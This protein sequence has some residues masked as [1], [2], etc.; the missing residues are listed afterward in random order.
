[1]D[2]DWVKGKERER[3][4]RKMREKE[5]REKTAIVDWLSFGG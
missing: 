5:G 4:R 3:E 1:M 2:F